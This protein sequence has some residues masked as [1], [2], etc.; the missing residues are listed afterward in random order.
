MSF[1]LGRNTG[2]FDYAR[3]ARF[4][5][6]S[7][8]RIK[9]IV[10]V[11]EEEET[12]DMHEFYLT[13]DGRSAIYIIHTAVDVDVQNMERNFSYAGVLISS[14]FREIDLASGDVVFE[15]YASNHT[16]PWESSTRLPAIHGPQVWDNM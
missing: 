16:D 9:S 8:Y 11:T 5:L 1:V 3:G 4:V 13:N 12:A 15:W 2:D 7:S 6:D 14:G 10:N